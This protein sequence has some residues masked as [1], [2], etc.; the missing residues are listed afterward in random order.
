[1][2][3]KQQLNEGVLEKIGNVIDQAHVGTLIRFLGK[4]FKW[5]PAK[6]EKAISL[7]QDVSGALENNPNYPAGNNMSEAAK[8]KMKESV[9]ITNI[10]NLFENAV[11][12]EQK[13]AKA[14]NKKK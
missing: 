1:M 14:K 5:D 12:K 13:E 8:A 2:K 3:N 7:L 4:K 6:V 10:L 9:Q 11:I